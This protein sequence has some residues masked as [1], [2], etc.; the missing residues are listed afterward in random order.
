MP[1]YDY[2]CDNPTCGF[3]D[4]EVRRVEQREDP[5]E[6]PQCKG[7]MTYRFPDTPPPVNIV[8]KKTL[9]L[10]G[11]APIHKT[12]TRSLGTGLGR[13]EPLKIAHEMEKLEKYDAEINKSEQAELTAKKVPKS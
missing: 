2:Q 3:K 4:F 11:R 8:D 5:L 10:P 13:I 9:N 6:C 12:R 1:S 7:P